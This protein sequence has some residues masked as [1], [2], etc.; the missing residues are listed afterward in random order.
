MLISTLYHGA[1]F[2]SA[3]L[4]GR[5]AKLYFA[6]WSVTCKGGRQWRVAAHDSGYA[7]FNRCRP[8]IGLWCVQHQPIVTRCRR[9]MAERPVVVVREGVW[10]MLQKLTE[11]IAECYAHAS[12][13]RER[14]KPTLDPATKKDFSRWN[15]GGCL[16]PTD[17][18]LQNG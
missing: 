6:Q 17:M 11:E 2:R 1:S 15:S 9:P 5:G 12:E 16:W 18:K 14:A 4:S 3:A 10:P 8:S 13:C 7:D